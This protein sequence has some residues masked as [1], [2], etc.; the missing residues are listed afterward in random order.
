MFHKKSERGQAIILI[1]FA[2]IG[3]IGITGLTVDGG[4]AYGDRRHAQNA[5][6]SAA[7]AAALA[8]SKNEDIESAAR[9]IATV[10]GYNNDG[11][12]NEVVVTVEASPTHACPFESTD[13]KDITVEITS[14]ANTYFAPIVGVRS[15]TNKVF[16]TTRACGTYIAPLFDGNAIVGLNPSTTDC[17]YDSG[18]S[19]AAKWKI[20]G[21]GIFSN[22]CAYS[23][24]N[25]SVDLT[26]KCVT[27][28]G[29]ASGFTCSHPNETAKR[30]NYPDDVLAIMPP[31]PCLSGGVGKPQ[32]ATTKVKGKDS[33]TLSDGVYCITNFDAYDSTDIVLDNATLYVTDLDF[34]V[35]FA[36][37]GGFSG[38]PT[39][40]GTYSS[41]YMIIAYDPT[42]CQSFHD[43]GSQRIEYR[44]NG[45][46]T[47]Y[48]TVLAPSA[49][50]DFRGNPDGSAIRSQIIAYNVS[51]NGNAA[52]SI[53]Y[54]D[55][56]QRRNPFNP[57][58][59]LIK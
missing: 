27:S 14:H 11:V 54:V 5:A 16:A 32:P 46:G 31:N 47:L 29:S 13:N 44:G 45:G 48:G 53:N 17:G 28:V 37:G 1:V 3:L 57:T 33:V 23:K 20:T 6:D 30:I 19:N 56:E 4:M 2:L 25:D 39:N 59:E 41:Y 50:I 49:C 40:S 58:I 38:T 24:N 51:S 21:G 18:N 15:I 8:N 34:D 43:N 52:V 36:G 9:S 55:D 42:P 26:G 10:N 7:F 22:G 12:Q 35:K